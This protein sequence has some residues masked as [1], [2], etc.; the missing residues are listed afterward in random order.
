MNRLDSDLLRT[1][2]AIA[3]AGSVTEGAARVFRTQSAASLQIKRLEA[4][5]GRSLFERHGRGVA[6]TADGRHL[7]LIAKDVVMRLDSALREFTSDG[8]RGKLRLGIPDDHVRATLTRIVGEFTQVHPFV[9]LEITCA[10]SVTFPKALEEGA[11]DLAV[12]EVEKPGEAEEVLYKDPTC[13]MTSPYRD[14][15][16]A[17]P[18]PVALF[19]P[20]CWWRDTAIASLLARQAPFREVYSSQSVAG[21]MSAV[22]AGVAVGLLGRSSLNENMIAL[23]RKHGF[24]PTPVSH[25]VLKAKDAETDEPLEAMK[26][27]IRSAFKAMPAYQQPPSAGPKRSKSSQVL[28]M[29]HPTER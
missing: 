12:Y 7:L 9:D 23:G 27:V 16:T 21:I 5:V 6:L 28:E 19:D 1:F 29:S 14:L 10:L 4:I 22:E 24:G 20:V 11:L 25:L 15:L 3:E 2:V 26:T 17:D 13:W 18:L 8:L